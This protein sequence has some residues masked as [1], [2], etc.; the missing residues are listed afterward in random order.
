MFRL[1]LPSLWTFVWP[2]GFIFFILYFGF[3]SCLEHLY[4]FTC[5]SLFLP[6]QCP[7][8]Y[9]CQVFS[10]IARFVLWV[11][12]LLCFVLIF[13]LSHC[14]WLVSPESCCSYVSTFADLWCPF[15]APVCLFSLLCCPLSCVSVA[16]HAQCSQLLTWLCSF[17][18]DSWILIHQK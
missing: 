2:L 12:S 17:C 6:P 7:F 4:L 13:I 11:I 18:L 15:K 9:C 3:W 5:F 16:V 1:F 10:R 14:P 8:A